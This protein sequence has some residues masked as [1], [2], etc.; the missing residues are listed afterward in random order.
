V[1]SR[2]WTYS[3]RELLDLVRQTF[4]IWN[5]GQKNAFILEDLSQKE[6]ESTVNKTA[7]Y[8]KIKTKK[9]YINKYIFL[10]QRR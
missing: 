3:D 10:C 7:N 4:Y 5:V 2:F 9:Q 8:G 6:T 1:G